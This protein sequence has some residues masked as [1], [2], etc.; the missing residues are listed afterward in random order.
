MSISVILICKNE[1]DNIKRC[2]DSV[3]WADEI[4]IVDAKSSDSTVE[5]CKL[6]TDKIFVKEW[7]G[8]GPQKQFALSKATKKW[9]LSLDADEVVTSALRSSINK[10]ICNPD[11]KDSYYLTRKLIVLGKAVYYGK[12]KDKVLRLAKTSTASFSSDLV[13][14]KFL[15]S[16]SEAN[17]SGFLEHHSFKNFS[18]M[19]NKINIYSS[20]GSNKSKKNSNLF[21]AVCKSCWAFFY[22]YFLRL[23]FL[24]KSRGFILAWYFAQDSFCKQ[25]KIWEKIITKE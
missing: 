9:V 12:G 11:S 14:E 15:S 16:G 7:C 6:Y 22:C 1:E 19:L 3:V 21:I 24:D 20:L 10:T 4:I 5:I 2:L 25:A 8:Y 13:H 23:G 17:L 18:T